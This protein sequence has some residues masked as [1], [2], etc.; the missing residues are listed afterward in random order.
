MRKQK[1]KKLEKINFK[2]I[3]EFFEN[4]DIPNEPIQLKA[5]VRLPNPNLTINI[6]TK[7]LVDN[8]GNKAFIPYYHTLTDIYKYYNNQNNERNN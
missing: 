8:S 2:V 5:G 7:L 3:K 4:N 6:L 1:S